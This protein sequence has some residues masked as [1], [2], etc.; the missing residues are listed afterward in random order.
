M[1]C[2]EF[3]SKGLRLPLKYQIF[4]WMFLL[5]FSWMLSGIDCYEIFCLFLKL[6]VGL[7]IQTI[8]CLP[9]N[10]LSCQS[11]VRSLTFVKIFVDSC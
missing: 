6:S 7:F 3:F 2:H 1:A 8:S 9:I 4:S 11:E 10:V 5:K